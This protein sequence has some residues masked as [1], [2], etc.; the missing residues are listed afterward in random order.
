MSA[1]CRS[2]M[3]FTELKEQ[4]FFV[5][6]S[7][8]DLMEIT[9]FFVGIHRHSAEIKGM[10]KNSRPESVLNG[11]E[12]ARVCNTLRESGDFLELNST[13]KQEFTGIQLNV[14]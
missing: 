14:V 3:E 12:N 7:T 4:L 6:M 13:N 1:K 2:S 9:L 5:N 10:H 11:M 8:A